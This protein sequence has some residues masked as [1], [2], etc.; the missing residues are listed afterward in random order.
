MGRPVSHLASL[1]LNLLVALREL[2]SERNVTRAAERLGVTQPAASAALARLRRHF[3]A[4][5]RV[6]DGGGSA[7]PA[8]AG[9]R[10]ERVAGV[11]GGAGRLF[12]AAP[13]FAPS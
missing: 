7:L 12:A 5:L 4:G 13:H 6:G 8:G 11:W 10:G 9:A 1:D 2:L 3:G